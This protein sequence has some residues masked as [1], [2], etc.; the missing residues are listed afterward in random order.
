MIANGDIASPQ[1]ALKV[2]QHTDCD[3]LMIG[4]AAQGNP[5]IFKQIKNFISAG[6]DATTPDPEEIIKTAQVHLE[7]MHEHYGDLAIKISRKHI[8]AYA[9]WL[10]NEV[11]LRNGFNQQTS[12]QA[13]QEYLSQMN[14]YNNNNGVLA[15]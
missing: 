9:D 7:K 5:W 3:G 12:R 6:I 13:Q 11:G 1:L 14:N 4:R 2:L 15:A 8:T 10:P